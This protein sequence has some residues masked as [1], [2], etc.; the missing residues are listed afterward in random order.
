MQGRMCLSI[1]R[2]KDRE[3]HWWLLGLPP[4]QQEMMYFYFFNNQSQILCNYFQSFKHTWNFWFQILMYE[5]GKGFIITYARHFQSQN[6]IVMF[7]FSSVSNVLLYEFT[8]QSSCFVIHYCNINFCLRDRLV[9]L[10]FKISWYV[11]SCD[12]NLFKALIY[13][14]RI[15][16]R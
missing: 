7:K 16:T 3:H 12:G 1:R 14:M 5:K 8:S 6:H 4:Q 10:F 13:P 11:T 9:C 15:K 2:P